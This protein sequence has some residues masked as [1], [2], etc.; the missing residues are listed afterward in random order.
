MT[1]LRIVS[2]TTGMGDAAGDMLLAR[3]GEPRACDGAEPR[4]SPR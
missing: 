3:V 2:F 4:T 1:A